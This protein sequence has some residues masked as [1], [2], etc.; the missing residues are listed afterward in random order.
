V[1]EVQTIHRRLQQ[2]KVELSCQEKLDRFDLMFDEKRNK[3]RHCIQ[4][5]TNTTRRPE[6]FLLD[7]YEPEAKCF[8][9]ERFGHPVE[10]DRYQAFGDEGTFVCGVDLI[11]KQSQRQPGNCLI[12]IVG[13]ANQINFLVSALKYMPY[14]EIHMFDP[15][16]SES[17][18]RG[19]NFSY[20]HPW[21][22]DTSNGGELPTKTFDQIQEELGH[23]GRRIDILKLD[24]D[25]CEWQVMPKVRD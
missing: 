16:I 1:E 18:F 2:Q 11:E 6:R 19:S 8:Q 24:C 15:K 10:F 5:I 4:L 21:G 14:C 7:Q 9:E 22:L 17:T 3:R 12:Y 23:L 25:N 20:F 13:D